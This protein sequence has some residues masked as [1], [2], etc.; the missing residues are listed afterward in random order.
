M[1]NKK[2]E[3]LLPSFM[4]KLGASQSE[5]PDLIIAAWPS[6]VGERLAPMAKAHSFEEG[7]L[8]VKVSNSSLLSLLAQNEKARL[9]GQLKKQFPAARI[10]DIRFRIG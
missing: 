4:R 10:S 7:I 2:L 8:T 1:A 3:T 6:L 9:L 5:R